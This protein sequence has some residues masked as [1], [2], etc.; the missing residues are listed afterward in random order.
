MYPKLWE[1][2]GISYGDL[3]DRL[4]QLALEKHKRDQ[5]LRHRILP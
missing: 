1:A 5:R 2:S 4:I 3:I